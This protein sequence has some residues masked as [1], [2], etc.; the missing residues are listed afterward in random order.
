M[1]KNK[2]LEELTK[3]AEL[4]LKLLPLILIVIFLGNV[5]FNF[6]YFL[7]IDPSY[8]QLLSI[9]DYYEGSIGFLYFAMMIFFPCCY[10]VFYANK[11]LPKIIFKI[12]ESISVVRILI[13]MNMD[14][15]FYFQKIV[16]ELIIVHLKYSRSHKYFNYKKRVLAVFL[17]FISNGNKLLIMLLKVSLTLFIFLFLFFNIVIPFFL[18]IFTLLCF[19]YLIG[20]TF[21]LINI[22]LIFLIRIKFS[23]IKNILA[24]F[25]GYLIFMGVLGFSMTERSYHRLNIPIGNIMGIRQSCCS[26]VILT[27][28]N[29]YRQLRILSKG[30]VVKED[31]NKYLF[32]PSDG[33]K[34][35]ET[36][37]QKSLDCKA[38]PRN[39]VSDAE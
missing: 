12:K 33:I 36:V 5:F 11:I 6:F 26:R 25:I 1:K 28:D 24:L 15:L 14:Y 31:E 39:E 21:C 16:F 3:Y 18:Q 37:W 7:N 2:T 27:D 29:Y 19:S 9:Q 34:R 4:S 17:R 38:E 10:Q 30:I 13:K 35:I 8:I 20:F 23:L 32:I 22:F